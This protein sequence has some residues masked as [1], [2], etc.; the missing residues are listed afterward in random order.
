[1]ICTMT[2]EQLETPRNI[3]HLDHTTKSTISPCNDARSSELCDDFE[4]GSKS[5]KLSKVVT[6]CN[7]FHS[8]SSEPQAK[9][10]APR[11]SSE[12]AKR[13]DSRASTAGSTR[14]LELQRSHQEYLDS[15]I[16]P[17]RKE[18]AR[19]SSI[20]ESKEVEVI[21]KNLGMG[22]NLTEDEKEKAAGLI[23][24]NYRGYR[25]RR[26]MNGMG[27]DPSSRWVDAVREA[28]YRNL[29]TPRARAD[30]LQLPATDDDVHRPSGAQHHWKKISTI[31]RRAAGD[32][33]SDDPSEED[34]ELTEAERE[35]R[36]QR[37]ALAK[38]E[39]RKAAKIMDLQYWLEA[40]DLKHRYGSN[41]RTYHEEW[42]RADTH[43][44]FFYWLDFGEGRYVEAAGCPRERLDRECVR[45]LSR[46]ERQHYLVKI[47]RE[48]RLCWAKNG[49]RIDT[50]I[51]FKDSINGI[52]AEDD[53][54]P[55]FVPAGGEAATGL[56][57]DST[58]SLSSSEESD[59]DD[60]HPH[61][62][63]E[64]TSDRQAKYATPELDS[65]KGVK[66]VKHVSASTIFNKLLRSSVKKNTWIYV[67]DTSFRLYVGI[68]QSGAFQHSSFLHGS[69]ISS[70]G[71]IKIK[72]G[73]LDKLSPLSGHY[74]PPTSSFKAFVHS[75]KDEGVD[76][77]HVS[78]SRSY[79]VLVGLEAYVK[80]RRKG[81]K[82]VRSLV[83]HRDKLLDPEEVKRRE[84]EARDKSESAA[85]ERRFLE[86]QQQQE[87]AE[88]R[89]A[90]V[91]LMEKL[92]LH[93]SSRTNESEPAESDLQ[94]PGT[95]PENGIAPEGRRNVEH[96]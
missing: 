50:S 71:L 14:S 29:T 90:N 38:Q 13:R 70:A 48:G 96:V 63:H 84:E 19:I 88:E 62:H 30:S 35:A 41:L 64:N 11:C 40:T 54:A 82:M 17:T 83:H 34:E 60:A 49:A 1:M 18:A 80:T 5:S 92:H 91:R 76:M 53:P 32:E 24:R 75:L 25:E 44:N 9:A 12:S 36:R 27:L 86:L 55:V 47:D 57:H 58:S 31:A 23:Q 65:A 51:H 87:S 21:K 56:Q 73:R 42:K 69:R 66:K 28:K 45:Y 6:K 85:R 43:E 81:K 2:S 67:A 74:R 52:V 22:T 94:A 61:H 33:D 26:Q 78:I 3:Y 93:R 77:S 37:R 79:A 89:A 95:G 16:P 39:R 8:A 10:Q 20:Q 68:K 72:D 59:D 7:P 15:L 4:T 46:E